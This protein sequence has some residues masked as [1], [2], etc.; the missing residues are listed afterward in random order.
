MT[1]VA[2]VRSE[3]ETLRNEARSLVDAAGSGES[4]AVA[5][6]DAIEKRVG[7][8]QAQE[9][10][11]A[12]LDELDRRAAGTPVDGSDPRFDALAGQVGILDVIRAG[13]GAT[14]AAAGRAR[15]ASAEI[16]RRSGR[17]AQGLMWDSGAE[18]RVMTTTA[19]A[20]GPGSNIIGPDY[21]PDMF[22]DRLRNATK[23]R[24]LGATVLGGLQGPVYVP[25]RK[26]S[27]TASWVA[28]GS[29]VSTSDQSF[30][31][32]TLSPKHVGA[33]TEFSR[34]LLQQASPD[35]EM[36]VRND[37]ALILAEAV[38][39]AA[40]Q[41]AGAPSPTGILST[42]GVTT[43]AL[44]TNGATLTYQNLVDMTAAPMNLNVDDASTAFM[45]NTK[46]RAALLKLLDGYGRPLG[47][48]LLLQG[49]PYAFSNTIP[50][51]LTKGSGTGLSALIYGKWSDLLIGV[52][53]ELDILVNPYE[54][55]AYPRGGVSVRAMA[56]V[57]VAVRHPESFA[58]IKDA[59][60]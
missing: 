33:L 39:T 3:I 32:V 35:V 10:R 34:Q 16:E 12:T 47:L 41:G 1:T 31:Q 46:V 57:D 49:K 13:M 56:T 14:D 23:V 38:D 5:R 48:D 26:A 28:E 15:E 58:V 43:L 19:P 24:G 6:F 55:S 17:K 59:V 51:N 20:G 4:V 37:M 40:T 42:S 18:R 2:A 29:N 45:T 9:R 11:L 52:W 50:S 27:H 7:E 8:L 25:R 30:D 54:A 53:S 21:R 22:I 36:L 44:G 60:A